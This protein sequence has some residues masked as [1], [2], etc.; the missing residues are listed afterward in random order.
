MKTI[1]F[2]HTT[3]LSIPKQDNPAYMTREEWNKIGEKGCYLVCKSFTELQTKYIVYKIEPKDNPINEET[4]TRIAEF[5]DSAIALN[6]TESVN[7]NLHDILD[8]IND[9]I[10][11]VLGD[12]EG[13]DETVLNIDEW[14]AKW[15]D[16]EK[17]L[18]KYY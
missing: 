10:V 5:W 4:V 2:T 14:K 15:G 11:N 16:I 12:K 8:S 3:F 1:D 9:D 13:I 18:K 17:I 6:W 7:N